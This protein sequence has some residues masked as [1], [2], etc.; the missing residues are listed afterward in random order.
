M[1]RSKLYDKFN[2]Q[3]TL[4]PYSHV[5]NDWNRQQPNKNVEFHSNRFLATIFHFF[6][7]P[8][9]AP[10]CTFVTESLICLHQRNVAICKRVKHSSIGQFF[11]F[12][13]P[14]LG[15]KLFTKPA[16]AKKVVIKKGAADLAPKERHA[17]RH[18]SKFKGVVSQHEI[19]ELLSGQQQHIT[20]HV[21]RHTAF[22]FNF[23]TTQR[24]SW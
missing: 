16:Q 24:R 19:P 20:H 15:Y 13:P 18:A 9:Q 17:K 11:S 4:K 14:L 7:P 21:T 12:L 2:S 10:Q 5:I 6:V 3:K 8:W 23:W 1:K 22:P